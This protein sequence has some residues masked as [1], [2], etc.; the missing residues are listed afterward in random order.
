[1][2]FTSKNVDLIFVQYRCFMNGVQFFKYNY[3]FHCTSDEKSDF[4]LANCRIFCTSDLNV[5]GLLVSAHFYNMEG[6][7]SVQKCQIR[8]F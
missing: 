3:W 6:K 4:F 1:M 7:S 5:G 8:L 2:G